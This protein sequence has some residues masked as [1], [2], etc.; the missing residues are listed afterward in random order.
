MICIWSGK[1]YEF[2]SLHHL[3]FITKI[4]N[5]FFF[6]ALRISFYCLFYSIL[7]PPFL[8]SWGRKEKLFVSFQSSILGHNIFGGKA[9]QICRPGK[10]LN[11][12]K[13]KI[14]LDFDF[15]VGVIQTQDIKLLCSQISKAESAITSPRFLS[16]SNTPH[17][18]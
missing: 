12:L 6:L 5:A 1:L 14:G 3:L 18:Q 11:S 13:I 15:G 16:H 8:Y 10:I 7:Y 4:Q 17:S 9:V 2:F